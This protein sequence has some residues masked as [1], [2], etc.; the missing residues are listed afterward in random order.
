MN[1]KLKKYRTYAELPFGRYHMITDKLV[2]GGLFACDADFVE[3]MNAMALCQ[4][5][6][7]VRILRF[8]L[9][10][11]HIHIV[12]E[13]T[14]KQCVDF[15]FSLERRLSW[16]LKR[17]GKSPLPAAYCFLLVPIR[18][19]RQL[20]D[21]ILYVDRNP[22][23]TSLNVLPGGY[24]WGTGYLGFSHMGKYLSRTH[25][26]HYSKRDCYG[27]F[28]TW[29]TVP[30]HYGMNPELKMIYPDN[31]VDTAAVVRLFKT[32]ARYQTRLS[33]AY[34]SFVQVAEASGEDLV[35]HSDDVTDIVRT[36]CRE[37]FKGAMISSLSREEKEQLAI[38]LHLDYR[39]DAETISS[40]LSIPPY[41]IRQLLQ[42]KKARPQNGSKKP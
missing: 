37:Q 20:A 18:D 3:G 11:N 34:E 39:M 1:P 5:R 22:Y 31:Y 10:W 36:V 38:R 28:H 13:A 26:S 25:V 24:L 40:Q 7:P 41:I 29:Q 27:F 19:P 33:K 2:K 16:L 9:M 14:G 42:S 23:D 8:T 4:L 17:T 35:F 6:H 32:A 12:L 30:G 15:F 21:T